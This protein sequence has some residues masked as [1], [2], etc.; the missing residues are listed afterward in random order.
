MDPVTGLVLPP[1]DLQAKYG[2]DAMDLVGKTGD[3]LP[4]FQLISPNS[5][6]AKKMRELRGGDFAIVR[7]SEDADALGESVDAIVCAFRPKAMRIPGN[8]TV[9]SYFNP[10]TDEFKKVMGEASVKDSGSM[11]GPEFLLWI[12]ALGTV[13]K[14]AT[15]FMGAASA[16]REGKKVQALLNKMA[17]FKSRLFEGDKYSWFIPV[18]TPCSTPAANQPDKGLY[19]EEMNKFLNA[20][21]SAIEKDV[22]GDFAQRSER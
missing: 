13:N 12:P 5:D 1:S 4:R 2:Q 21:D 10:T 14:F 16:R 7:G 22:V 19:D 6:I 8:G 15:Y 3:F 11:F 9:A 18:I 20:A 17:T